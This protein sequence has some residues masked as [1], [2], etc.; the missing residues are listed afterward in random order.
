V[1][2]PQSRSALS[3]MRLPTH[4]GQ[5]SVVLAAKDANQ[6]CFG[7]GSSYRSALASDYGS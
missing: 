7:S 6:V 4:F 5:V 3:A 1:K 2:L